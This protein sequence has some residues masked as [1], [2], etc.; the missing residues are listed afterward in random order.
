MKKLRKL[1]IIFLNIMMI[2]VINVSIVNAKNVNCRLKAFNLKQD[3]LN[4]ENSCSDLG[5]EPGM[6]YSVTPSK[7]NAFYN[8]YK[9]SFEDRN[10]INESLNNFGGMCGGMTSLVIQNYYGL[11]DVSPYGVSNIH[12]LQK[13]SIDENVRDLVGINQ[14]VYYGS[15]Y[16][17]AQNNFMLNYK[18]DMAIKCLYDHACNIEYTNAPVWVDFAWVSESSTFDLFDGTGAGAHS[19]MVYGIQTAKNMYTVD[20][21]EYK[22]RLL[23]VDPNVNYSKIKLKTENYIYISENLDEC[24]IPNTGATSGNGSGYHIYNHGKMKSKGDFI[25]QLITDDLNVIR[26]L[27]SIE[28]LNRQS[29]N[30]K[31]NS[32]IKSTPSIVLDKTSVS[33]RVNEE[34]KIEA[35]SR[36]TVNNIQWSSSNSKIVSVDNNGVIHAL[37]KGTATITAS[38][39][40][41]SKKCRITVTKKQANNSN[42]TKAK[43]EYLSYLTKSQDYNSRF[44]VTDIDGDKM[45]ELITVTQYGSMSIEKYDA[46]YQ[47]WDSFVGPNHRKEISAG[48]KIYINKSKNYA[49]EFMM[50]GSTCQYYVLNLKTGKMIRM[51]WSLEDGSTFRGIYGG[52][53]EK[54][55]SMKWQKELNNYLKGTVCYSANSTKL[56]ANTAINRKKYLS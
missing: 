9:I 18:D 8:S 31:I 43:A 35:T 1:A 40:G 36:N 16:I 42:I 27:G 12:D 26:S 2:L 38:V 55:E 23:I 44:A 17:K 14:S 13:P 21:K 48:D 30:Q 32:W 15:K 49:V 33:V 34:S 5:V 41:K 19:L 24:I 3:T 7:M 37:K 25:F 22:Y 54:I 11:L 4:F 29:D 39:S 20:D 51:Y 45:P 28:Y 10:S 50:S 56:Y 46:V 52:N 6:K 47:G 53:R